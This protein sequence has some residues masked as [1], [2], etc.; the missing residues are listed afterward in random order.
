MTKIPRNNK[1]KTPFDFAV[2]Y[3][4]KEVCRIFNFTILPTI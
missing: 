1:G 4:H 3:G 2:K